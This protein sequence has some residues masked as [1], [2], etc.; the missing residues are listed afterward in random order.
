MNQHPSDQR[1][2]KSTLKLSAL[3]SN[4]ET[5]KQNPVPPLKI[6]PSPVAAQSDARPV[7][8]SRKSSQLSLLKPQEP[9]PIAPDVIEPLRAI[10]N[11]PIAEEI[12]KKRINIILRK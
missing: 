1:D 7:M 5:P 9:D 11:L 8:E 12:D 10:R 2:R 3:A 4:A 6:P